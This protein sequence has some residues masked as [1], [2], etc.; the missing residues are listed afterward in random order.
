M[1]SG[2]FWIFACPSNI[3]I[4]KKVHH[5][6]CECFILGKFQTCRHPAL[7]SSPMIHFADDFV[8]G[9]L[10]R[11]TWLI[12]EDLKPSHFYFFRVQALNEA[13]ITGEFVGTRVK[14]ACK[15]GKCD[16]SASFPGFLGLMKSFHETCLSSLRWVLQNGLVGVILWPQRPGKKKSRGLKRS[17]GFW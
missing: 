13:G 4:D 17:S 14:T 15:L 6:K 11:R 16:L 2:Q 10:D 1:E 5:V 3:K 12:V 8:V 7:G 9:R